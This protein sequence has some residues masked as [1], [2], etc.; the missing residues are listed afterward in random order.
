MSNILGT[1][2]VLA[3]PNLKCSTAYYIE[4]LGFELV[5]EPPG[6]AFIKREAFMLMLG[7]CPD[8]VPPKELGDHTY[9]AYINVSNAESLFDEFSS[10]SV[11]FRKQLTNE[12][13]GMKEFAIESID[14]HVT[15]FGGDV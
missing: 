11:A 8:A 5:A 6:W 14:G 2:Y 9:F 3:V 10:K 12:P 4:Q 7:E 15:M 1:Q 13:W